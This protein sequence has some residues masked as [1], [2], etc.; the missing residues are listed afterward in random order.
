MQEIKKYQVPYCDY[1]IDI[2]II[3]GALGHQDTLVTRTYEKE[4]VSK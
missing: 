4:T 3:S 1:G 2:D